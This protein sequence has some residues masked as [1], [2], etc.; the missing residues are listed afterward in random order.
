MQAFELN[1]G[2][3]LPAIG[4]GT[5]PMKSGTLNRAVDF[6]MNNHL[7]VQGRLL[8][9]SARA[10]GNEKDLGKSLMRLFKKKVVKR[11]NVFITTKISN[12]QQIAYNKGKPI[13]EDIKKSLS[14]LK[15]DCIDLLLMH[16]PYPNLYKNTWRLMENILKT[17]MVKSIGV[18]NF[19]ERHL[20][21]LLEDATFI[22]SVNQIEIHPLRTAKN[23][24]AF[25]QRHRIQI[26]AYCPLGLMDN[27][28]RSS[29][30]LK[31]IAELHTK[32]IAQIILRWDYQ[33]NIAS[34]PKSSTPERIKSNFDIFNFEL[35]DEEMRLIDSLNEDYKFY[36]ESFYCPGY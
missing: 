12:G 18:C 29:A 36:S 32:S 9:D 7:N 14:D 28:I 25:C 1:D 15:L 6:F 27:K 23:D 21:S 3:S 22:P 33:Q 10:Y 17:G 13:E 5:F 16:W 35:T 20:R 2:N 31:Q 11:E 19:Q 24:V 30:V 26:Q 8:L 4:L 34:V